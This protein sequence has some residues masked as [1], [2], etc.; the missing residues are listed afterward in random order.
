MRDRRDSHRLELAAVALKGAAAAREPSGGEDYRAL[1]VRGAGVLPT[2]RQEPPAAH[3]VLPDSLSATFPAS[4][5][6]GALRTRPA[7]LVAVV[8]LLARG[9]AQLVAQLQTR[10]RGGPCAAVRQLPPATTGSEPG[11]PAPLPSSIRSRALERL[12]A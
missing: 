7:G 4:D 6:R 12:P 2:R 1:T 8:E 3:D 11:L 10:T 5:R 9:A